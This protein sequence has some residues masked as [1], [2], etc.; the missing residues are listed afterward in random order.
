MAFRNWFPTFHRV[1]SRRSLS[2]PPSLELLESRTVLSGDPIVGP[3]IP[4]PPPEPILLGRVCD[5]DNPGIYY[6]P[7][8]L[9][10]C[11]VGGESAD[12]VNVFIDNGNFVAVLN[13]GTT[14]FTFS[15]AGNQVVRVDVDSR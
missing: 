6:D 4:L 1:G 3:P 10:V 15:T 14:Q 7:T 11:V 2:I 12:R 8:T 9:T 13:T 5:F